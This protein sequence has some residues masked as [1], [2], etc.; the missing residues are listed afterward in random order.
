M[1]QGSI[2]ALVTP[3]NQAGEIDFGALRELIDWHIESGTHGIVPVGT[4]GESATLSDQEQAAVI[5]ATVKHVAGKVPVIAGTGANATAKTLTLTQTAQR[6]GADACLI[7]TP[8]Y[9]KPTQEGL[10]Q[11]YC[12]VADAVDLP[13]VLYNVPPRTSCDMLA[14]TVS[15]LARHDNIVGIKEAC[16]DAQRVTQIRGQVERDFVVLSGEDGQT[17]EMLLLGATGTISVVANV[18]PTRIAQ[19]CKYY[20]IGEVHKA[21]ELDD[22]LRPLYQVLFVETNPIPVKWALYQMG[23]IQPGIRLPLTPLSTAYHSNLATH[24]QRIN[25]S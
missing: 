5:E 11:H 21:Q 2:V 16:G 8:Y 17:L 6:L 15:R 25:S 14:E 22:L 23:R 9:N 10:Y 19:L 18:Q 7:V 12:T 4:T 20:L 24:L 13:I 1:L 3:M